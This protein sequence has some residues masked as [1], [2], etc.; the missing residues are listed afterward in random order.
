VLANASRAFAEVGAEYQVLL[1]QIA[2]T[3][4]MVLGEGCSIR[5][6]S[7]DG[8][9]LPLAALYDVDP[10]QLKLH[11]IVLGDAPLRMDEPSLS[12]QIVQSQQSM[13]VPVVD[14]KQVRAV[15]K[16]EFWSLVERLAI[17]SMLVVPL[18]VR[19][20]TIGILGLY[21]YWRAQP[22][23]NED[24]LTLAQDL[25]DRAALAISNAHL[26]QQVQAEL[27]ER[28]KAEAEVRA[29]SVELEQRVAARTSELTAA[30][31]ELEAFSY[32]ISH[33]L[34]APLRAING[35]SRI[36]LEDYAAILP[37]EAQHYLRRVCVNADQMGHL[38]DDLLSFS[39]LSRQPLS[40][41]PIAHAEL[42][43]QCVEDLRD[44]QKG[45]QIT[46]HI[47]N[48]PDCAADPA[49]LRQVWINLIA[50]AIKYTR[51]REHA[52]IEIG[53]QTEGA[54]TIYFIRDNGVG[55]DMRYSDKLFG[56]FQRMHRAEDYEGTGV[57]LAIVQRVIIRH[58]GRIWAEA[59]VDQGA[60]FFFT[61]MPEPDAAG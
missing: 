42:V 23:F 21:R 10:E 59:A 35:F 8:M 54:A 44:D 15:T 5:M 25:A 33:D 30:N 45:R 12:W 46:I 29:L 19:G 55:F 49:L 20:Q 51:R 43:R 22:S 1:D 18:R 40:R 17:H 11:R 9:Q 31:K 4:A 50:N 52:Q 38:I 16:P 41:Y 60:T 32:S 7:D 48:L 47:D 61:I 3:T 36:L 34:R 27:A 53:S 26:F 24:D 13:L 6:L 2:Q 39:R 37:E 57:G 14:Q 58:H 56:V 28:A